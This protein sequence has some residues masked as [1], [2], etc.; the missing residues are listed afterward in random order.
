MSN[1]EIAYVQRRYGDIW[2]AGFNRNGGIPLQRLRLIDPVK[3]CDL[4]EEDAFYEPPK[5]SIR[6]TGNLMLGLSRVYGHQ[7]DDLY[8]VTWSLNTSQITYDAVMRAGQIAGC[9]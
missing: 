9:K 1:Q 7:T 4:I 6:T 5:I 3:Y 2:M 8:E